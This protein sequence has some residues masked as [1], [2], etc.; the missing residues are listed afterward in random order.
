MLFLISVKPTLD[1]TG[2]KNLKVKVGE[3]I[4]YDIKIGGEPQPDVE[5]LQG[6]KSLKPGVRIKMQNE[7]TKAMLK[8]EN[9]ERGDSGKYTIELRNASGET[10]A[11]AM[12]IVIGEF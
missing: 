1:T 2:M 7:R 5:W 10:S 11:S 12:V 3:T 9:A 6:T 4:K 8:I